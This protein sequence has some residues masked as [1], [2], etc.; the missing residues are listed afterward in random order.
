M[1]RMVGRTIKVSKKRKPISQASTLRNLLPNPSLNSRTNRSSA[2][3]S[4]LLATA[5]SDE[6]YPGLGQLGIGLSS[7]VRLVEAMVDSKLIG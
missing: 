3:L 5:L 4:F 2:Q 6:L 1:A 7:I